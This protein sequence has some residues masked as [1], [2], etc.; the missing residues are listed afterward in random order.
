MSRTNNTVPVE[1]T[2]LAQHPERY[3]GS[4]VRVK[5]TVG[6]FGEGTLFTASGMT[7]SFDCDGFGLK[8]RDD[9]L[10]TSQLVELRSAAQKVFDRFRKEH[11]DLAWPEVEAEVE[12]IAR[13]EMPDR[14]FARYA[15]ASVELLSFRL[16]RVIALED[17][18]PHQKLRRFPISGV[19]KRPN[20]SPEPTALL[21]TPRADARVAPSN[22]VAHL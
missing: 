22:A 2:Q 8:S 6:L 5:C 18:S 21:V 11:P 7:P 4:T 15:F 14:K 20:Q 3:V 12:I 19:E 16:A 1:F 9:W 10:A 17:A 13:L